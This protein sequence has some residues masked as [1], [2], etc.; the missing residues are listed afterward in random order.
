MEE[1]RWQRTVGGEWDISEKKIRKGLYEQI[2]E[3]NVS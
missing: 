3:W 2:F 1:D